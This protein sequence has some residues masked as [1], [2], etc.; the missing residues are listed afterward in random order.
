MN[1][2]G[3]SQEVIDRIKGVLAEFPN[4]EQVILF[5]SRAKGTQKPGSDIDLAFTGAGLNW[6]VL[7]KI[8][9]SL[10]DLLLPYRFSLIVYNEK[11]D[12]ELAAHIRR[13]GV[14]LFERRPLNEDERQRP[15][16]R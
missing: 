1:R 2:H 13:V 6:R 11:T 10:D 12:P 5:G 15:V 4:V 14:T 3:L 7:V 16:S 9:D 8:E